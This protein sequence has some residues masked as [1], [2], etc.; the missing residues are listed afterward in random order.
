MLKIKSFFRL[1]YRVY[2]VAKFSPKVCSRLT[3]KVAD[4]VVPARF[5]VVLFSIQFVL[6]CQSDIF[7]GCGQYDGK[8]ACC[9]L[10]IASVSDLST[11]FSYIQKVRTPQFHHCT[12]S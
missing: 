5:L 10:S 9:G 7:I 8:G 3:T 2:R 1:D 12:L 4:L 11:S 6:S